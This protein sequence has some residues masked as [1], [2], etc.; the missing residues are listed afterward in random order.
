MRPSMS[1]WMNMKLKWNICNKEKYIIMNKKLIFIIVPL[2]FLH[3]FSVGQDRNARQKIESARIA[4]ITERLGLTPEQAE[5]FWPIYN[6]YNMY[7]RGLINDLQEARRN[8]DMNN[9]SE[10]QGQKLMKLGL[11][12]KER[13]LQLEKNYA[14]RLNEVI[15]AQQIM[16]LRNA[17]EDFRRMIIQRLEDRKRQQLRRDQMINRREELLKNRGN[18]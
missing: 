15:T 7:R 8:V 16:S 2:L 4:L 3:Q 11:D 17:E 5:R 13:Q 12:I 14:Q 18:N 1:F 9:L 6:E 10:E